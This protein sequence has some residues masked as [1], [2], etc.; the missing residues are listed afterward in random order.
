MNDVTP[1]TFQTDD[2]GIGVLKELVGVISEPGQPSEYSQGQHRRYPDQLGGKRC[3]LT[4]AIVLSHRLPL[5]PNQVASDAAIV[6]A[7]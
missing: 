5:A 3:N 6:N 2:S 1:G 4:V 7:T